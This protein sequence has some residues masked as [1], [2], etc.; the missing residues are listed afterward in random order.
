[1]A[2]A[3]ETRIINRLATEFAAVDGIRNAYGFADNP[4]SLNRTQ[5]PA[6]VFIPARFVSGPKAHPKLFKN[7]FEIVAVVL[8]AERESMGGRL[9]YLE[10]AA[11]PFLGKVRKHFQNSAVVDRLFRTGNFTNVMQFEGTYGAG[12]N[13]LTYNGIEYI[14]CIFTWNLVEI[15]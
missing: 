2:R 6:V 12:G 3:D 13:L 4:D 10:N 1:M 9:K 14:G 8:V 15:T 5:L 11:L 7:E